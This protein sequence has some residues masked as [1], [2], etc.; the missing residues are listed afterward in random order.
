VS[1]PAIWITRPEPGN[2]PST[3]ALRSAG[4]TVI[5]VPVLEVRHVSPPGGIP[6]E[7]PDWIVFVSQNA[8]RGLDASGAVPLG[9]R[10]QVRVAAVGSRT[11]LEA[12]GLGWNVELVPSSEN[13]E[14]LLEIL[15]R[16]DLRDRRVWIPCGNREGSARNVLAGALG[17]R[18]ARVTL[19][20]VY[21]TL[22]R[23]LTAEDTSRLNA[24]EPG[25]IVLH[26]SSA[27]AAV[28]RQ[29]APA[30]VRRWHDAD[31]IAVGP[32]TGAR[33]RDVRPDR[34]WECAEPSDVA[35]AA[36]VASLRKFAPEGN[37]A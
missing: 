17:R 15:G 32:A 19:L 33:C 36:L 18:G 16:V 7:P 4:F 20:P 5:A 2:A 3:A 27:V 34:I 21:E 28:F 10:S 26:S 29:P 1:V 35:L 22:D 23:P 13:A 37:R 11:A 25:A 8:V 12:A 30:A 14:G 24:A 31:L 6:P 9:R